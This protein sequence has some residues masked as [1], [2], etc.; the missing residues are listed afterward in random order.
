MML[1]KQKGETKVDEIYL[2]NYTVKDIPD[3]YRIQCRLCQ[4]I[5]DTERDSDRK[6]ARWNKREHKKSLKHFIDLTH[7]LNTFY[8]IYEKK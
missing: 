5:E 1:N 7:A 3:L 2:G 4:K 8:G 6:R